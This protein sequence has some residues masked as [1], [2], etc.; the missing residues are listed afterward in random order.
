MNTRTNNL[1]AAALG[2]QTQMIWSPF[3]T[4]Q[5]AGSVCRGLALSSSR[6]LA[7]SLEHGLPSQSQVLLECLENRLGYQIANVL[8][9][10][11]QNDEYQNDE[12]QNSDKN[13]GNQDSPAPPIAP[14]S[15]HWWNCP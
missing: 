11:S 4:P 14:T 15:L 3:A 9:N 7:L 5:L 2:N 13:K 12:Y 6:C 8:G 10:V 1:I